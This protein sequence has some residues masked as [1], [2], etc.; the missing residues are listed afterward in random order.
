MFLRLIQVV[1]V[2]HSFLLLS[3]LLCEYVTVC[4][5]SFHFPVDEHLNYFLT[6]INKGTVNN[7]V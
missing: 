4:F 2:V 1:L 6:I 7:L 3:I 5:F